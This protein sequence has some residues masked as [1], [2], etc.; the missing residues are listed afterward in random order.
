MI[1][2]LKS[3]FGQL[4]RLSP[5][6]QSQPLLDSFFVI[7]PIDLAPFS[8]FPID[9]APFFFLP[10]SLHPY[11]FPKQKKDGKGGYFD[12]IIAARCQTSDAF[13]C[14][15]V[16]KKTCR[17]AFF[18]SSSHLHQFIESRSCWNSFPLLDLVWP[19]SC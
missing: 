16:A 5:V 8:S 3:Y 12:S 2:N 11:L 13:D 10:L 18:R 14:F 1:A 6:A 9:L 15:Y 17:S 7:I 4:P 19:P